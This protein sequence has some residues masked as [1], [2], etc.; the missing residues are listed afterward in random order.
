[1]VIAL[2]AD[3]GL[4]EAQ[5]RDSLDIKIGQ[6]I[7]IGV[8]GTGPDA[9]VLEEIRQGKAGSIIFF[10]KNI[11]SK[12]AYATLK[13]MAWTYKQVA[14]IPLFVAIDQEGG[15]VNRL[16]EK[17]GFPSSITAEAMGASLDSV[18]Y[19]GQSTAAILSGLG[20]N[21]NF[22][23]VLD[24]ASNPD[25]PII[26]KVGRAFSAHEDTVA[27]YAR[28]FIKTHRRA[29]VLTVLKH[30]PGHGSSRQDTHLG[31]ADVTKT[32]NERELKPYKVLIDSGYADAIMT[33]HIVNKALDPKGLP[34]TLSKAILD[35]LLRKT[36]H[37]QGVVFSDDMQMHAITK[38][39]GL[40]EA[41]RLAINAGVDI[42][43][44]S[45]NIA[46]SE[47]RTVDKV[48][49]IITKLVKQG[50]IAEAQIDRSFHRIMD[51]KAHLATT[52]EN[53]LATELAKSKEALR[54]LQ[55][56]YDSLKQE[57]IKREIPEKGEIDSKPEYQNPKKKKRKRK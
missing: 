27:I 9:E 14:P 50:A 23:P 30:F 18:R 37:Y 42:L 28:E 52:Q 25:N 49:G 51:L 10:E 40:E 29:G 41:I 36:L 4:V 3:V 20:I 47:E 15:K 55:S 54:T 8:P 21:V 1:M 56:Q 32:W 48:H 11:S 34:G 44:F 19:Y 45:N 46:G 53:Y 35:S 5:E 26:A 33:A 43:T 17:Y 39:Y 24:L 31:M 2:A 22:A 57:A 7:L 16:K 6:M 12:N 38:H 13:K